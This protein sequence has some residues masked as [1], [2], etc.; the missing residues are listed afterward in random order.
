MVTSGSEGFKLKKNDK[1]GVRFLLFRTWFRDIL[2][3][4]KPTHVVYEEVMRWS[5]GAAAKCYCGLL[6]IMQTECESKQIP[7]S[8][9]SVGTIKKSATGSGI[10]SKEQMIKA[11][12]DKGYAPVDDNE[13]D[14]LALLLFSIRD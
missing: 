14:A 11:M 8:G 13:A 10:A 12:Q 4:V 9:V 7:Y 3:S 6:A 1:P 5:S 2:V